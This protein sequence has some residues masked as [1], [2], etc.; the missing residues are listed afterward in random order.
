MVLTKR[1]TKLETEDSGLPAPFLAFDVV[2]GL[3][4]PRH[5]FGVK[6]L[7]LLG[8]IAEIDELSPPTPGEDSINSSSS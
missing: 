6:R 5:D 7:I 8:E 1:S 3:P 4:L 2:A